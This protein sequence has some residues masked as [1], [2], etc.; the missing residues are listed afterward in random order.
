VRGLVEF[1]KS[2]GKEAEHRFDAGYKF[3]KEGGDP[4]EFDS[5]WANRET[6]TRDGKTYYRIGGKLYE[7]N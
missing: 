5:L 6:K 3:V 1:M 2:K 4:L 7:A